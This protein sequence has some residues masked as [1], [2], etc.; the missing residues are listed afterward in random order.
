LFLVFFLFSLIFFESTN[1]FGD[2]TGINVRERHDTAI[3]INIPVNASSITLPPPLV[4]DIYKNS[5]WM[6]IL[7]DNLDKLEYYTPF[8]F[9]D[10]HTTGWLTKINL[11][12]SDSNNNV[13]GYLMTS[14]DFQD[15]VSGYIRSAGAIVDQQV[16]SHVCSYNNNI[17]PTSLVVD[18]Q[19]SPEF[20][21]VKGTAVIDPL[22]TQNPLYDESFIAFVANR[23]T[24]YL[25]Q[26]NGD[27]MQAYEIGPGAFFSLDGVQT[28]SSASFA[29]SS[30]LTRLGI[31]IDPSY[32]ICSSSLCFIQPYYILV[33]HKNQPVA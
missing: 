7:I 18:Y 10:T 15:N 28:F 31:N 4:F 29:S 22:P 9:I 26:F 8:G 2:D 21:F 19:C 12:V 32:Q 24:K 11:L 23:T 16:P 14:I 13:P 17:Q 5:A 33:D 20:G 1:A 6:S 27:V 30:P 3:Y 25:H